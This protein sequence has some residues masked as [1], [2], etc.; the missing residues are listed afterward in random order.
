MKR[1]FK[2]VS[3]LTI[4]TIALNVLSVFILM[5]PISALTALSDT[6]SSRTP[7]VSATHTIAFTTD[8]GTGAVITFPVNFTGTAATV[9]TNCSATGALEITCTGLTVGVQSVEVTGLTN[10]VSGHYNVN[11][12]VSGDTPASADII[13]HIG[14]VVGTGNDVMSRA[15]INQYSQHDISYTFAVSPADGEIFTVTFPT[16]SAFDCTD[17]VVGDVTDVS[18]NWTATAATAS[19]CV[20]TLTAGSGASNPLTFSVASTHMKNPSAVLAYNI[21]LEGSDEALVLQVPIVDS[22]TVY[23]TGFISSSLVFDI[24]TGSGETP[25]FP[26]VTPVVNCGPT[27]CLGHSADSSPF[28]TNYTVDLGNL[29]I[30]TILNKSGNE[31]LHSDGLSGDINSIYFDLSTNASGGAIVTYQSLYGELRGPGHSNTII[32]DLDIP[33]TDGSVD[34]AMGTKGYGIQLT[35]APAYENISGTATVNCGKGEVDDYYCVMGIIQ[36]GTGLNTQGPLPL[37]TVTGP[38]ENAR[39]KVDVAAAIDGT[40]VPGVYTD[41]LTFIA[42]STF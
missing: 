40:N 28:P 10:P 9:T 8:T 36:A 25:Q 22:D 7:S 21:Y 35:S 30:D 37:Y 2:I 4:F 23:I 14:D 38:I 13:V 33:T 29:T 16:A 26:V 3:L 5:E 12:A 17:L 24:D 32:D 31:V 1:N 42:T 11:V 6:L 27:T 39:G 41:Q 19:P 34:I 18:S 20:V 15:A